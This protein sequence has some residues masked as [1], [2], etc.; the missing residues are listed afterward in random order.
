MLRISNEDTRSKSTCQIFG[1]DRI[2][3]DGWFLTDAR[4]ERPTMLDP[5]QDREWV[6]MLPGT[7]SAIVATLV[8]SIEES[9]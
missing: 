2:P 9:T 7:T 8:R 5:N 6:K 1:A 3:R 4:L